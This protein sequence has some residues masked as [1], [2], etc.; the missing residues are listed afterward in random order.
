MGKVAKKF[1]LFPFHSIVVNHDITLK[2]FLELALHHHDV[3]L[4]EG[5]LDENYEQCGSERS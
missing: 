3:D 1:L 2:S 5:I 4:V